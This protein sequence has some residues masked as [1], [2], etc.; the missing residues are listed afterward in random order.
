MG[1]VLGLIRQ[2][3]DLGHRRHLPR[4]RPLD[5]RQ[6]RLD[7]DLRRPVPPDLQRTSCSSSAASSAAPITPDQARALGLDRQL[8]GQ[9]D[10]RGGARPARAALGLASLRRRDRAA[11]LDRPDLQGRRRPVRPRRASTQILRDDGYTEP[12]FVAE[13]QRLTCAASSPRPS[14]ATCTLPK[15]MRRGAQP[16]QNEQRAIEY[17]VLDRGQGRRHRGA[18]RRSAREVLR[19]AQGRVPRARISPIVIMSLTPADARQAG[20]GVR[21]RRASATTTAIKRPLRHA[22]TRD[23]QQI[24]FPD[25]DEAQGRLRPD[26]ARASTFEA[27]AKERG[28]TETATSISAS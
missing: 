1:V 27:I 23:L 10:R 13:Q 20:R 17:V 2:L 3:R 26:Q 22:G 25:A 6:G 15:T 19:G 11:D 5:R 21:R 18:R 7:R 12:R 16:L 28:L 9:L 14:A 8:L 24:V 4:L